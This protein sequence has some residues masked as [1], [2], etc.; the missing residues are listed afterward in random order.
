MDRYVHGAVEEALDLIGMQVEGENAI[1]SGRLEQV[2]DQACRD[3]FAA[4]VLAVLPGIPVE[5]DHDGDGPCRGPF[6]RVDHDEL[7]HDR[8]VDGG[9]VALQHEAVGAANGLLIADVDLTIGEIEGP[10][11]DQRGAELGGDLGGQ[12]GVSASGEEQRL[13]AASVLNSHRRPPSWISRE[14]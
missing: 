7:F 13:A 6:Q 14:R 10:G 11:V 3:R 12:G 1:G 4:A 9:G 2:C 8:V 5:G